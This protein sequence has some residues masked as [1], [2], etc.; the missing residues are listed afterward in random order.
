MNTLRLFIADDE[1]PARMLLREYLRGMQDVILVGEAENG[2]ESVSLIN[3]VKP[4]A[5]ILGCADA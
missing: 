2:A 1:P 4:D 5:V 3:D